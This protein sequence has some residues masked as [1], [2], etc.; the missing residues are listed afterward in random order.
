MAKLTST[1]IYGS[2]YVQGL[3][4]V[5]RLNVAEATLPPLIINSNALVNN[6][7]ADLLDGQHGSYYAPLSSIP[8]VN[9]G[10]LTLG[11][12]GIATGSATFTANQ[13]GNS[14]FTVNVPGTNLSASATEG[15]VSIASST[16]TNIDAF[17]VATGSL[18]GILNASTQTIG[19]NKTFSNNVVISGNLTVSGSN[20]VLNTTTVTTQ[21]DVIQLRSGASVPM[22]GLAGLAVTKYDGT[23]D[24][25]I[26]INNSGEFRVGDVTIESNGSITDVGT[27]PLLARAETSSLVNNDI[28]VWDSANLKAIGKTLAE[29]G[30]AES[31]SIGNATI[32]ITAGSGL[33]TGGSF[34]TNQSA[35]A[36]IT[37][38]HANTSSQASS[39]NSGYTYIQ[40]ITLDGFGHITGI[41]TSTWSHPDTSSQASIGPLTGANVVSAVSLDDDGHVTALSTRSLTL[42]DLGYTTS[43]VSFNEITVTNDAVGDVPITVNAI[44]G[45]T[46]LLQRWQIN[47]T[48]LASINSTGDYSGRYGF[49]TSGVANAATV[50]NSRLDLN[51]TGSVISRNIA[52]ANTAL[53]VNQIHASSTGDVLKVQAAGTDRLTVKRDGNIGI[54]WTGA[55]IIDKLTVAGNITVGSSGYI[56][57]NTRIAGAG[58]SIRLNASNTASDQ[59]IAFGI[60]ASGDSISF[61]ERMRIATDGKVGIGT[62]APSESLEVSGTGTQTIKVTSTDSTQAGLYL[63]RGTNSDGS[64]DVHLFNNNGV[65]R[66]QS[67]TPSVIE[68]FTILA[69][70]KVGIGINSPAARLS[71][72]DGSNANTYLQIT[73]NATGTALTDGLNILQ[74]GLNS[75]F[76]NREN[77]FM[78]F[79]T[80]NTEKMRILADGKVGIGT[81]GPVR[82][83]SVSTTANDDG[84][85]VTRKSTSTNDYAS[86]GFLVSTS[87]VN[88][89][90]GEIRA[91]RTNR[92]VSADTDLRFF[93]YRN[94][95]QLESMVIRDDGNVGIGGTS[96][97]DRLVVSGGRVRV[98]GVNKLAFGN[99]QGGYAD[100]GV[101]G[102]TEG[103]M[104]FRN[105]DGSAY[106]ERMRIVNTSGNVGIGSISPSE[107][108]EIH[109]NTKS[110]DYIISDSTNVAKAAMRYDSVSKS[111]K[112]TFA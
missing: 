6:L 74:S 91:V 92:D 11:T 93:T 76:I 13:S 14:T 69:D 64:H 31:S 19:G 82:S 51:T 107:K 47:G 70:G 54:G 4:T 22:T 112:F 98:D 20:T 81:T 62:T 16:G 90:F 77:G 7:N 12:S 60:N 109:G 67:I 85:M 71:V 3:S 96:P 32:T 68:R 66:I 39:D 1:D 56:R 105:W 28:F 57:S 59:Y 9:N 43:N 8:V 26:L 30:I 80:N 97:N 103:T 75:T 2:L 33:A 65:F 79:E 17:P 84:I 72:H 83:L 41:G 104:V 21:D 111:I 110:Q 27:V 86:L 95:S 100:I 38:A 48:V 94:G 99:N 46:A 29:L 73:N 35:N 87:E 101:T 61:T 42:G 36:T 78:S 49:F 44:T 89:K 45:T 5:L 108:L 102:V 37:I 53:I 15:G 10:T 52:D 24:G 106:Q 34:T 23:H 55:D 18:A 50:N 58:G 63:Q 25:G 88:T 40:D